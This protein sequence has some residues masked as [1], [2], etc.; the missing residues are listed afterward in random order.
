MFDHS[1]KST[2]ITLLPSRWDPNANVMTVK[3]K[4]PK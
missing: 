4:P 1:H 2:E 3:D